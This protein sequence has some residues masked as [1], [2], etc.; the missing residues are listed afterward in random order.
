MTGLGKLTAGIAHE[1]NNPAAAVQ[2]SVDQ[3][4]DGLSKWQRLTIALEAQTFTQPQAE[5]LSMLREE[6][7]KRAT[8]PVI[9]DPLARSDREAVLESWLDDHSVDEAWE[10]SPLLVS[11]GW[12]VSDLDDLTDEFS[13][14]QLA[15]IVPWLAAGCAAYQLIDEVGKGASQISQI[16]K[17]VKTYSF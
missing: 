9:L 5:K 8:K 14:E 4:R 2:R 11:L 16:V 10:L 17:A 7:V 1:L 6:M 13:A 15:V 3:L 12:A